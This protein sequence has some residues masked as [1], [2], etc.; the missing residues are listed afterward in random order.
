MGFG[1]LDG[2]SFCESCT[3]LDNKIEHVPG[4]V[5]LDE[6][7]AHNEVATHL[8][9]GIG[10]NAHIVLAPQPSEDPN[11]PLNWSLWKRDLNFAV[12]CYGTVLTSATL[13]PMLNPATVVLATIFDRSITDIVVMSS[14]AQLSTACIGYLALGCKLISCRPF[15]CGFSRKIGKRPV[16]LFAGIAAVIGTLVCEVANDYNT[17]LAGRLVQGLCTSA[18]ESLVCASIGFPL[19]PSVTHPIVICTSSMNVATVFLSTIS[20]LS[21]LR[22]CK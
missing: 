16:Y 17:L 11:D 8:K 14:Y 15:V 10:R 3:Y 4:T 22:T 19:L 18:F 5:L 13:I 12:L 2:N 9:H 1:V 21:S 20:L 7:A 6:E